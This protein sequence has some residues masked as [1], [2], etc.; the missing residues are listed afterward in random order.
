MSR[1]G[2]SILIAAAAVLA[3]VCLFLLL[4]G[5]ESDFSAKY[6]GVD[7]N[8]D[9]TGIGRENTYDAY[10]A[11][12]QDLPAVR[13]AVQVDLNAM[14]GDG[15]LREEGVYTADSSET[16]WAVQVPQ[17]GLYHIRMD[18]LTVESRGVDVENYHDPQHL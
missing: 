14:T 18:Y 7:L 3:A 10:L 16:T 6:A 9:V 11:R 2:R 12:Y 13:E 8:A 5:G 17:E 15:Q 4:S 1:R